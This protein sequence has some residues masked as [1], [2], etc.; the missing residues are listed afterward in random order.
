MTASTALQTAKHAVGKHAPAILTAISVMGVVGTAVMASRDTL[1]ARDVLTQMEMEQPETTRKDVIMKVAPCYIP[2][3]L[4]GGATIACVIGAHAANTGKIAA[5]ASAY[6]LAQEAASK[7][8]DKVVEVVGEKKA[9]EIQESYSKD[10]A[11]SHLTGST[12]IPQ[13]DDGKELCY[14]SISGRW[15]R[16]DAET[17]RHIQN[18]L[19][20]QLINEMWL[21]LNNF[22]YAC[23]LSPINLGEEMGWDA[24]HLI[25]LR[26]TGGLTE[27][28]TPYIVVDHEIPPKADFYRKY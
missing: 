27:N 14:D 8:R 28:G 26:L 10:I 15:F 9:N 6:G 21:S 2:T 19:N 24:D 1:I 20:H 13:L 5:Y 22:Y 12:E 16:S 23:G 4:M 7:Y 18:D 25:E 3:L 11:E 17:L